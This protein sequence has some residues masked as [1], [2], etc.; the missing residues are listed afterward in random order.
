MGVASQRRHKAIAVLGDRPRRWPEISYRTLGKSARH[1][2]VCRKR[3]YSFV[4]LAC[5]FWVRNGKTL[6][7][8]ADLQCEGRGAYPTSNLGRCN[9]K[10]R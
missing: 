8:G 5:A 4:E 10:W 7:G 2:I 1:S 6:V 9:G 3:A